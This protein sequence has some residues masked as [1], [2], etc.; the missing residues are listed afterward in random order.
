MY[1]L[2]EE[3]GAIQRLRGVMMLALV[4]A[5]AWIFQLSTLLWVLQLIVPGTVYRG[6][7]Y[8]STGIA[9]YLFPELDNGI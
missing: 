5:V 9:E 7:Y 6:C 1:K 8:V 2:L 4:Y 3:T